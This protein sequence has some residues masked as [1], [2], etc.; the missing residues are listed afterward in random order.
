MIN[1][2]YTVY[3]EI[4]TGYGLKQIVNDYIKSTPLL[5]LECLFIFD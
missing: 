3:T 5:S 4:I 1:M 2:H